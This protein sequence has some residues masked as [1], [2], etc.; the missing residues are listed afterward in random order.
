MSPPADARP[1]TVAGL[2]LL[3]Q[4]GQGGE[5]EVWEARD[6][7]G[8]RRALKL[9]RPDALVDPGEVERRGRWLLGID[10]PALVTVHRCGVLRGGGLDGWGFV[11]MAFVDGPDLD[12]TE[13]DWSF[14]DRLGPL[15]EALD[16]LHAGHWSD[17]VPLVHRDVKPAN[18]IETVGGTLVLV[19]HSTLRDVDDS[20][21]TRIGTPLFAAPEV[22]TGRAG[23][24]ADVYS[25]AAT[26]VALVTGARRGELGELLAV[27]DELD[28]PEGLRAALAP[29]P[30]DRPVS[31]RAAI[32]PALPL[33]V[34]ADVGWEP[35]REP[36]S[37]AD[38]YGSDDD[39]LP[40][41]TEVMLE[42]WHDPGEG[43]RHERTPGALLAAWGWLLALGG[44][45]AVPL[46]GALAPLVGRERW[47][48]LAAVGLVHLVMVRL[49]GR[50]FTQGLLVPPVA[51]AFLLADRAAPP[52]SAS[53]SASRAWARAA[54]L[55]GTLALLAAAVGTL[56]VP[57]RVDP[58]SA[59]AIAIAAWAALALTLHAAAGSL[60]LRWAL[61]PLWVAGAVGL[62]V[63]GTALLPFAALVGRGRS[64]LGVV[65]ATV[66]GITALVRR[67]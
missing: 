33:I 35:G 5:G 27:P 8:R 15:A 23:P 32:D 41:A 37:S 67:P 43:I 46:L 61:T 45:A 42:P 39:W 14:L 17:G 29:H 52:A 30:A 28:L 38:L 51:W 54:C 60:L 26:A 64:L 24:L 62:V 53:A 47:T 22:V 10:H 59:L 19:D 13:G 63:G 7:T 25:F 11:E 21:R 12:A 1:R 31:C 6:R 2:R 36:G 18:L 16:L 9:I 57:E 48:T 49:A 55:G 44:L 3:E 65:T 40:A 34:G 50:S 20:T 4:V 56:A 58:A 66:G